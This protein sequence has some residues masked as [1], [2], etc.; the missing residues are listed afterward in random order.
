MID[1]QV[2]CGLRFSWRSISMCIMTNPTLQ[3][4]RL[5]YVFSSLSSCSIT[6]IIVLTAITPR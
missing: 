6:M 4:D 2:H 3:A 1:L 5:C